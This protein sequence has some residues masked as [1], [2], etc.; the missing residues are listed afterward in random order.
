M[1]IGHTKQHA[2]VD[3]VIVTTGLLRMNWFQYC[4]Q[5]YCISQPI[6]YIKSQTYQLSARVVYRMGKFRIAYA[7]GWSMPVELKNKKI[8]K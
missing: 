5:K 7:S 4:I 6:E 3:V 8:Y 2:C 1:H